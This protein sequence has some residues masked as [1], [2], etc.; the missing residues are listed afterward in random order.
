LA[1]PKEGL[2]CDILSFIHSMHIYQLPTVYWQEDG[3]GWNVG[4]KHKGKAE[5]KKPLEEQ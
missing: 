4:G 1:Y 5:V 3:L 2:K